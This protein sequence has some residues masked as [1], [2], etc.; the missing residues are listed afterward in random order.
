VSA[1]T[2]PGGASRPGTRSWLGD[3][4]RAGAAPAACAA[5]LI[6]LLS[7]WVATGGAGTVTPVRIQISLA[8]VPMRGFTAAADTAAKTAATYL[9]IRNLS[10]TPDELISVR[11]P[12]ARRIVLRRRTSPAGGSV[13]PALAIPADASVTLSPFG[14]DVVLMDPVPFEADGSVP[15]TLTFRHAGQVTVNAAVTAP[16]TP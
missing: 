9:T 15:L 13:V 11:S 6:G 1:A 5:V 2:A 7:A 8:A 14:N 4:A 10:G 12:V 3:A 16:G